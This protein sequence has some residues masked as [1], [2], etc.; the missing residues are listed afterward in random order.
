M[1]EAKAGASWLGRV[2]SSRAHGALILGNNDHLISRPSSC[3]STEESENE[4]LIDL[5][6]SVGMTASGRSRSGMQFVDWE[7]QLDHDG[8]NSV[9]TR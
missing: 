9:E 4:V 8:C 3:S 5:R 6:G 2:S 1:V 7:E